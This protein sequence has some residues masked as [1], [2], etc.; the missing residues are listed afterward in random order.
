MGVKKY[1]R[2]GDGGRWDAPH[3]MLR[4]DAT[5]SVDVPMEDV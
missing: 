5:L 4:L 3:L 2:D 1:V